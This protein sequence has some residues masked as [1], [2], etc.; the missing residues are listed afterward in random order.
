MC[1]TYFINNLLMKK[2]KGSLEN[3]F[4]TAAEFQLRN[5]IFRASI[6][7]NFM[8]NVLFSAKMTNSLY[9]AQKANTVN[10]EKILSLHKKVRVSC[11]L[12]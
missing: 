7:Y 6:Q 2:V 5:A 3:I 10:N 1:H 8:A 12:H 11:C 9:F 4:E